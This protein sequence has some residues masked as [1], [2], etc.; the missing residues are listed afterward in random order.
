MNRNASSNLTAA[1]SYHFSAGSEG[2]CAVGGLSAADEAKSVTVS[3]KF[4]NATGRPVRRWNV[5]FA[6]EKYRNGLVGCA[7]RL[8]CSADGVAW[9]EA[10]EPAAFPADADTAGYAVEACPGANLNVERRVAFGLPVTP[11]GVFYL[12]WQVSVT[13]GEVTADAQALG[14]DDVQVAPV[15]SGLSA[16]T[17]R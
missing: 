4:R 3:A 11:G 5:R 6:A 15:V 17:V 8:L 10:G 13:A 12:A 1:G 7:V 2:D 9:S 16:L 14:I